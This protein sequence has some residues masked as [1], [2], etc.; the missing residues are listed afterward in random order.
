MGKDHRESLGISDQDRGF[1]A[2]MIGQ[3][4]RGRQKSQGLRVVV[5]YFE[6]DFVSHFVPNLLKGIEIGYRRDC[7]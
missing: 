1:E 2:D 4:S 3:Y 7:L 6:C 5:E